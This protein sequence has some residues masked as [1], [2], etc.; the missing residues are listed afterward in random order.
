MND[1][2]TC[3]ITG[4]GGFIG[5]HLS[6][7]LLNAGYHVRA[8]V[9]YN[10]LDSLGH[11]SEIER[12]HPQA[13]ACLEIIRGDVRD[14]R[15]MRELIAGVDQVFHLA[16]LIAIPY[17]YRAPQSYVETNVT[18]TLN[19]L[20]TCRDAAVERLLV[21]S[22]SETLGTAQ[23]TPQ[24]ETHPLQAQSPY[25]ASKIA[26]DKLAESYHLSF[27]LPVVTVRPFNTYGPRQ[28]ARAVIPTIISQAL[29]ESCDAIRLG[30]LDPV[31]DW[32][33]VGDTASAFVQIAQAPAEAVIGQLFHLGSGEGVSIGQMAETILELIDCKKPIV[34]TSERTRPPQSEVM[35]LISDHQ[36]ISN[37][38]GWHPGTSREDG[39]RQTIDYIA[40]NMQHYRPHEFTV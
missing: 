8:L 5:S 39:L 10:A 23:V 38:I 40:A 24:D 26:A 25:A 35:A 36:Q 21:T 27:N 2:K 4:A 9:H 19:V 15:C 11:L 13:D 20:E 34:Q 17:S 7:Q 18:G 31:R 6:A 14:A 16:A 3:A 28:S 29:S 30:S 37:A 22:T 32:T 1:K 33:Y 12:E